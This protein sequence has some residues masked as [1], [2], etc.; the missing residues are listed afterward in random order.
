MRANPDDVRRKAEALIR[1]GLLDSE[2]D[3]AVHVG[4]PLAVMDPNGTQ[5]S[6]FV[7]LEVGE[8]LAGFAQLLT[9]LVPMR[10]SSFQRRPQ[11]YEH[12]PDL[13]DW[14][15]VR[16]IATR[17]A[18]LA[19]QGEQLSEPMLTYDGNPS[20]L[21]WRVEAKSSSGGTRRLFVAGTAVYEEGGAQ[22]LV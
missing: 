15:D 19:R 12:C 11:D 21:A 16:R 1:E 6:W 17:A 20:R 4:D 7:P 18:S 22:G 2:P 10:I 3:A 5:H 9:S 14:T 13:A 8:K